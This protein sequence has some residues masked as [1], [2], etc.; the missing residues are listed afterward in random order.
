MSC[1]NMLTHFVVFGLGLVLGL[2]SFSLFP[3]C[4]FFNNAPA[5]TRAV[6]DC[7]CVDGADCVCVDCKACPHCLAK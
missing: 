5:C 4:P 1:K 6:C 2:M 7:G 3:G